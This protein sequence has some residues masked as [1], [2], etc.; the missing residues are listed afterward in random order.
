MHLAVKGVVAGGQVLRAVD[1][2]RGAEAGDGLAAEQF[3]L[4]EA[5]IGEDAVL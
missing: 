5:V 3:V 4:A 2:R 1:R